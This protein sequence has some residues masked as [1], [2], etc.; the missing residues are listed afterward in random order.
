[1]DFRAICAHL[2]RIKQLVVSGSQQRLTFAY[3]AI[4]FCVDRCRSCACREEREPAS[5]R[6]RYRDGI[7]SV[8]GESRC[9]LSLSM[10]SRARCTADSRASEGVVLATHT[11][12][13]SKCVSY[14][15]NAANPV[16]FS[17]EFLLLLA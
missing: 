17:S 6:T 13:E 9:T 1:M 12:V 15:T 3:E 4:L 16:P 5:V 8:I 10:E 7:N 11:E 2:L 14:T